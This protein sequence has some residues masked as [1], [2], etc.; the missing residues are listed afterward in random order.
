MLHARFQT[1][2]RWKKYLTQSAAGEIDES[3]FPQR[4][5][6]VA[7]LSKFKNREDIP[8][9][10][11]PDNVPEYFRVLPMME[12]AGAEKV[13]TLL[14]ADLDKG[15][16]VEVPDWTL[17]GEKLEGLGETERRSLVERGIDIEGFLAGAVKL[18]LNAAGIP[19]YKRLYP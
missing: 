2:N 12:Y 9:F 15:K 17:Y 1:P 4:K 16:T 14:I 13:A 5:Q 7:L 3:E 18:P 6:I 11:M 19:Q 10:R 8:Y